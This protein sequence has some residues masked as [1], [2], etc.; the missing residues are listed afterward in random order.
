MTTKKPAPPKKPTRKPTAAFNWRLT[1][2]FLIFLLISGVILW[3]F[4]HST[5]PGGPAVNPLPLPTNPETFARQVTKD[6]KNLIFAGV[7]KAAKSMPEPHILR[8]RG[9][10][11]G[12]S[13]Q[14]ENPLWVSYRLDHTNA[15]S[16]PPRPKKFTVDSRTQSRVRQDDYKNSG[17]DRG[18]MAPNHGIALRYGNEG[19]LETFF[20]SNIVPQRPELNRKLWVRLERLE[21][22]FADSFEQ[23]WVMTGPIFDRNR[24]TMDSGV[25]IP[26][27]FYKIFVDENNGQFRMLSFIIPQN[28]HGNEKIQSF[29]ASVDQVEE[30]SGFD[31]FWALTDPFENRI[32]EQ[33]A[34]AL[35]R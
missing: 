3:K 33:K 26:D 11:A 10:V 21:N 20:M 25:E 30:A 17:Y 9:Y 27:A 19:Q 35:W 15:V 6:E 1:V 16:A 28:V 14:R 31:F 18:H 13:E 8:N 24:E 2:F 4:W 29:F 12:Y 22:E 34:S 23:L 7:P 32:E 5:H